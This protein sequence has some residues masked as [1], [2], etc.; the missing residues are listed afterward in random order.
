MV[1]VTARVDAPPA[2]STP[3][4]SG[5]LR[6]SVK[7]SSSSSTRSPLMGT[8]I[9]CEALLLAAKVRVPLSVV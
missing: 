1:P 2:S 7:V 5:L 8:R 6:V 4:G 3:G 9:V